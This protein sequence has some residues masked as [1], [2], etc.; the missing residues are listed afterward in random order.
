MPKASDKFMTEVT[1]IVDYFRR[2]Y[3]LSYSEAIGVL[4]MVKHDLLSESKAEEE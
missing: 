3:Q 4:E 1:R 2:E